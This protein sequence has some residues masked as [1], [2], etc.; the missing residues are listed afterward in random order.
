MSGPDWIGLKS[1]A[2]FL[3]SWNP[4]FPTNFLCTHHSPKQTRSLGIVFNPSPSYPKLATHENKRKINTYPYL[5]PSILVSLISIHPT[6]H[7]HIDLPQILLLPHLPPDQNTSIALSFQL[8]T[9]F[10][11]LGFKAF[12]VWFLSPKPILFSRYIV[13]ALTWPVSLLLHKFSFILHLS[14]TQLSNRTLCY[15]WQ[16]VQ[17][18]KMDHSCFEPVTH[19][20]LVMNIRMTRWLTSG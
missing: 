6:Y 18:G 4:N 2:L 8:Y 12:P 7:C 14:Q 3:F 5:R 20:L 16:C 19:T 17:L 9:R 10:F 11:W 15:R 1:N 13:T